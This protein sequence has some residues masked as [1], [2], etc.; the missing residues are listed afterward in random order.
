MSVLLRG[1]QLYGEGDPVD[2][3]VADGQ[4]ADIGA[5]LAES[6]GLEKASD[7]IDATGH[8]N[9]NG[10]FSFIARTDAPTCPECGSIMIPNG[11]CHKCVNCGT[12]SGCS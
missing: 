9:G 11:S 7:V 1:V 2:V 4:I 8:V 3:L 12:T 10:N 5:G 6:G